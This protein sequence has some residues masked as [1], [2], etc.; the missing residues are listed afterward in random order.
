MMKKCRD[1]TKGYVE[2]I[3]MYILVALRIILKH[4]G[5]C[6]KMKIVTQQISL[7]GKRIRCFKMLWFAYG[8]YNGENN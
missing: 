7:K 3:W 1:C 8:R 5:K 4:I 6:G 2:S